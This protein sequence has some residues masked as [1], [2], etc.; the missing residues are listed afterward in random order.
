ML[1]LRLQRMLMP[2]QSAS[3]RGV[4]GRRGTSCD[5]PENVRPVPAQWV[6]PHRPRLAM[7]ASWPGIVLNNLQGS[8]RIT[9]RRVRDAVFCKRR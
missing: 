2:V 9:C 4:A 3:P 5:V 8:R 7:L 1:F 6:R